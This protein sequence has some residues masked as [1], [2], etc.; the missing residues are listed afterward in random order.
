MKHGSKH[1]PTT[2]TTNPTF[3]KPSQAK[4]L[5]LAF[6]IHYSLKMR[7][8]RMSL[9]VLLM[10]VAAV[11]MAETV[12]RGRARQ[13]ATTFLNNNGAQTRGLKD[14]TSATGFSNVYVFTTENSFVLMAADDRVQPILGYSL[15]G[16]F[17]IE[18]M[19]DNKR[20]WI[21]GYGD[22]IQYAIAH[23][24]RASAEVAQQWRDLVEGNPR[25]G[26]ATTEV[27][28]LVQTQWNQDA[29]YNM[30]CPGGTVTGCV[31]TAMAQIMKYWNYPE[32]GVGSHSYN[33]ATYGEL[34]ADFQSTIYDWD[35][36]TNTYD[37]VSTETEKLAVATLMY[38]C[39]VSVDM[40]YSLNGSSAGSAIV[41]EALRNYFN[42]S[43][44][45]VYLS[46]S[47]Y[48]DDVWIGMLKADLDLNR[49]IWYRGVSSLVGHAF[50]F[51]GYNSDDYFHVNWG[52]GGYCD[53]YYVVNNLN[54]GPG[55]IGSGAYGVYNDSQGAVFGLH[56]SECTADAPSDL[57]YMLDGRNVTLSWSAA[58]GASGYK[59]YHSD[60]FIGDAS[61]TSFTDV[62]P[63][64]SSVY[65][66]RSVD[67]LGVL[68]LSSNAVTVT[69]DYPIPVVDDLE[70][71]VSDH[72]VN[73]TWSAP[74][75]CYPETP[76]AMM[77]Y[78]NGN[79]YGGIGSNGSYDFYWGHRYL[80]S[81]LDSYDNMKVYKVSFYANETGPY[82]VFV[83]NGTTSNHPQTLLLQQS[84][85]VGATGWWDVDLSTPIQI[86][87]S[88]D[89]WV[90][91]CDPESRACPATFCI[92]SGSEGNYYSG[93]PASGVSNYLN[94]AFLIRTFVTDGVYTY[95]VYRN[96][97]CIAN[98]VNGT[99]YTDANLT[100]GVY[101]YYL[102]TNYYGGET[103][104]SNQAVALIGVS[105]VDLAEGQNWFS[106]NVDITLDD[107]KAALVAAAPGTAIT[108]QSQTL[109]TS[110]NPNNGRWTG[111]L[112]TLDVTR[113]YVIT[114]TTDCEMVLNGMPVNPA[115]H[116]VTIAS[117][118]NW[119]AYPLG[120]STTLTE[121]FAG[122]AV[123]GDMV[124][125]QTNNA[126][127]IR[128]NWMGQLTELVPGKGYIYNSAATESRIFYFPTS[129]K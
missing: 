56:P 16:R 55:G 36:M 12:D 128:N 26:R 27:A 53:E 30:L 19:P 48:D 91:I 93:D 87:A 39:G 94:T 86:D 85:S 82:K 14:V 37:T 120:Q 124:Q 3:T 121:A 110:Y 42:Y 122:F 115:E 80:A 20:V 17:D 64:G 1:N 44:E 46:R 40:N 111:Q 76:S 129:A 67:S 71:T 96:D 112:T 22:E 2:M 70:A 125:S 127:Y 63:Y 61:A 52:W 11:T 21:E 49:P 45:T 95:N 68:S 51:D 10:L 38:H 108:I 65:Y 75:W 88:Q 5:L 119:I 13:A 50:V 101:S 47:G 106:P 104:A 66:V 74:D 114:V 33:H 118:A 24:T 77:T 99:S 90:F 58:A 69:I 9:V 100:D 73:L 18:H 4:A 84:F 81:N 41:A 105:V 78:G 102:K 109:N 103:D 7:A 62:A 31:A 123:Q 32:H 8:L 92:Y 107:L 43:S 35:N 28:P 89:L 15:T 25:S 98:N 117:G 72:D 83:Y 113:M 23:Q 60:L 79:C 54:P 59:V 116:P 126:S 97:T 29:P 34:S 57:T 6:K